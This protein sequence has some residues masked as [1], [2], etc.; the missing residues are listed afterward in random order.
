MEN[1]GIT[2]FENIY[3]L[4]HNR[5]CRRETVLIAMAIFRCYSLPAC[6]TMQDVNICI[7]EL[8]DELLN[9]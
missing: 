4:L 8:Q 3:F 6:P 7:K 9:L 5:P 2:V 1:F